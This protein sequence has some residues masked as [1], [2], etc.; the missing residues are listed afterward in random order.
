MMQTLKNLTLQARIALIVLAAAL[1]GCVVMMAVT[2]ARSALTYFSGEYVAEIQQTHIGVALTEGTGDQDDALVPDGGALIANTEALL[3]RPVA[4]DPNN[5]DSA[6]IPGEV[7]SERLSVQNRSSDM[8][9][10]V[11]LT[12]RKYWATG[13]EGDGQAADTRVKTD[14]LN[15]ALIQLQFT[16]ESAQHWVRADAECT[17]E[18]EV[19]YYKTV[20]P[21]GEAAEYPAITGISIDTTIKDVREDYS[22]CW[23]AL[24]AQVDSVQVNNAP[25]AAK[26]A[27]GVDVS[28]LG[29]DWSQE[30]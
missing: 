6:I 10:Y 2:P 29:L 26:S 4:D 3:K 17:P 13:D 1:V 12:V 20:L 30:G 7:Y 27:W 24:E 14:K 16:D 18:R 15:P 5:V 25:A 9:E 23:L 21:A 22:H 19:F 11:R 28:A 8:D